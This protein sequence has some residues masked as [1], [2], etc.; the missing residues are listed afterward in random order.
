MIAIDIK[1]SNFDHN[2]KERWMHYCKEKNIDFISVNIYDSKIVE[3]L[4]DQSVRYSFTA[5]ANV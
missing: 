1:A 2:Y 5:F 4:I 3:I